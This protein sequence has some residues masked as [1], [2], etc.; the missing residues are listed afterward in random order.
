MSD[1]RNWVD[2]V[3]N[4]SEV[5]N[6]LKEFSDNMIDEY[7]IDSI[8][9]FYC[10]YAVRSIIAKYEKK[11]DINSAQI[12]FSYLWSRSKNL[13]LE[14]FLIGLGFDK[15]LV[16]QIIFSEYNTLEKIRKVNYKELMDIGV[17]ENEAKEFTEQ[18][19][20]LSDEIDSLLHSGL[21]R[22]NSK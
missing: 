5:Y 17:K 21:I 18:M 6:W 4:G 11:D 14:E 22:I 10:I 8:I 15:N 3:M 20:Y 9:D 16:N 7:H 12:F 1:V 2:V 19:I 13:K